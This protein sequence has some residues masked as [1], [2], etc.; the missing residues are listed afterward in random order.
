MFVRA[1]RFILLYLFALDHHVLTDA[2]FDKVATAKKIFMLK[3]SE[4]ERRHGVMVFVLEKQLEEDIEYKVVGPL[5][6]EDYITTNE[7]LHIYGFDTW[8]AASQWM[9]ENNPELQE[10][11]AE[12]GEDKVLQFAGVRSI[13]GFHI[14]PLNDPSKFHL[15]KR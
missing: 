5:G 8:G 7:G 13:F 4:K 1:V 11:L 12:Y 9:I 2:T 14:W 15:V 10:L 6:D 3:P